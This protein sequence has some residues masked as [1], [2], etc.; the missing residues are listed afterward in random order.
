VKRVV[1]SPA[2]A[3]DLEGIADYIAAD[4]PTRA[5][6]FIKEIRRRCRLLGRFPLSARRIPE[7]CANAHILPYRSYVILYRNTRSVVSIERVLHGARDILSL[8][9]DTGLPDAEPE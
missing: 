2:A 7:L 3:A 1:F 5:L 6:S 9:G 4:N 8:M